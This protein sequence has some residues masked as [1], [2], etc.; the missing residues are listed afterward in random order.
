[1]FSSKYIILLDRVTENVEAKES[2][3]SLIPTLNESPNIFIVL[4]GKLNA[5]LKKAIDKNAEKAVI[6]DLKERPLAKE[7]PNIFALAS[8]FGAS[9]A[10]KAWSLFRQAAD[11]GTEPEAIAGMLFW[12]AKSMGSSALARKLIVMYHEAHRGRN[13]LGVV[14]RTAGLGLRKALS[15]LICQARA[16][17]SAW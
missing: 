16:R 15:V 4:E 3:P 1:M 2:L 11:A 13:D 5:D 7:S 9:D 6:S 14:A 8:A 12:K 17:S 10:F